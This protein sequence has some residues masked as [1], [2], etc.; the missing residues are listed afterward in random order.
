VQKGPGAIRDRSRIFIPASGSAIGIYPLDSSPGSDCP[1][2]SL[3]HVLSTASS[4]ALLLE[5]WIA[6]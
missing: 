1:V 3:G 4:V 6:L 2:L 5:W